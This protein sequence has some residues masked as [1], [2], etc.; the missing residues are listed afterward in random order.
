M[1]P[2][3]NA[4]P[5]GYSYPDNDNVFRQNQLKLSVN[6]SVKAEI[7]KFRYKELVDSFLTD[8]RIEWV[9]TLLQCVQGY[10]EINMEIIELLEEEVQRENQLLLDRLVHEHPEATKEFLETQFGM[11]AIR[12]NFEEPVC[13]TPTIHRVWSESKN[14]CQLA[15]SRHGVGVRTA[16]TQTLIHEQKQSYNENLNQGPKGIL[17][18]FN[19]NAQPDTEKDLYARD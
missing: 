5:S 14:I 1:A 7:E 10:D 9:D 11:Q 18:S 4:F 16:S 2:S 3:A 8:D 13:L 12:I 19:K 17:G 6:G 15:K